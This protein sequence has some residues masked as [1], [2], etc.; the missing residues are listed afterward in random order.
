VHKK[1]LREFKFDQLVISLIK[2]FRELV[3]DDKAPK[4]LLK[5]SAVMQEGKE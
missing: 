5:K 2:K 3:K 1:V 4:W